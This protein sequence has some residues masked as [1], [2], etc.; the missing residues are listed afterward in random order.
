LRGLG[1]IGVHGTQCRG[2]L[3]MQAVLA[4]SGM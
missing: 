3:R 2:D 4:T 1:V